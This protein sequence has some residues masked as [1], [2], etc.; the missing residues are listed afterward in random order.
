MRAFLLSQTALTS[1]LIQFINK[2]IL[3]WEV[4]KS[5]TWAIVYKMCSSHS[6][7]KNMF[8][9]YS[10]HT[11]V[12]RNCDQLRDWPK[13]VVLKVGFSSKINLYGH[14]I[15]WCFHPVSTGKSTFLIYFIPFFKNRLFLWKKIQEEKSSVY[16][17]IKRVL[18]NADQNSVSEYQFT[19]NRLLLHIISV[20]KEK[21]G[22]PW[23]R[24]GG[25][26]RGSG[27]FKMCDVSGW[28]VYWKLHIRLTKLFFDQLSWYTQ[29]LCSPNANISCYV[30]SSLRFPP[31]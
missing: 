4:N 22:F 28:T 23:G 16:T 3:W 7:E 20:T 5:K 12:P 14:F 6:V 18:W 1:I 13:V 29:M 2:Q 8:P 25:E 24:G 30:F 27:I 21:R 9:F 10:N 19:P 11:Q 31:I 15:E 17:P 26:R